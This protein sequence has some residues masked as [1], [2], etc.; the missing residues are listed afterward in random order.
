[1]AEYKIYKGKRCRF[2]VEQYIIEQNKKSCKNNNLK[3]SFSEMYNNR[4]E[5]SWLKLINI[6]IYTYKKNMFNLFFRLLP[7]FLKW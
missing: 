4:N 7:V 2:W 6:P 5:K 1:M 3:C